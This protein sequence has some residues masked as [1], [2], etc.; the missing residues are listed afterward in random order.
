MF[1][2]LAV[3]LFLLS[4]T[5]VA[6]AAQNLPPWARNVEDPEG[7]SASV[8]LKT[9]SGEDGAAQFGY[10]CYNDKDKFT[11][12][13]GAYFIILDKPGSVCMKDPIQNV[14]LYIDGKAYSDVFD[15]QM[16]G[17]SLYLEWGERSRADLH[18]QDEFSNAVDRSRSKEMFVIITESKHYSFRAS[19]KNALVRKQVYTACNAKQ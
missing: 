3:A 16:R 1:R 13:S 5:P 19:L 12:G 2:R 15:C 8:K 17:R 6:G 18:A 9:M 11:V 4:G 14:S 7:H 10:R